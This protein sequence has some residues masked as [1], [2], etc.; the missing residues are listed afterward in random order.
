M[1]QPLGYEIL[2]D[3]DLVYLL[4]RAL[5][6]LKQARCQWLLK[7]ASLLKKLGFEPISAD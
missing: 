3:Q 7:L 1:E 6:G 5:Y 2:G 4:K